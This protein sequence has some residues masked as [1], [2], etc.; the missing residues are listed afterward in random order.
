[1]QHNGSLGGG[2]ADLQQGARVVA[3]PRTCSCCCVNLRT[4]AS[5]D[6]AAAPYDVTSVEVE[7]LATWMHLQGLRIR[8]RTANLSRPRLH[9]AIVA[10]SDDFEVLSF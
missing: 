7:C 9:L 6:E 10:S 1:M 4:A 5:Y 2:A 8:C 3:G